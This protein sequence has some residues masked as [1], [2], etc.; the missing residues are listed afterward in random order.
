MKI[1]VAFLTTLIAGAMVIGSAP[2]LAD[3]DG[4]GK[5]VISTPLAPAAIGPYSQAIRVGR[6]L[7][8]SGEIAIDPTTNQFM[9]GAS[10]EDQTDRVLKNLAGILTAAGLTLDNV[11]ATTVYL[12]D[13]NDFA[14]MNQVYATFFPHAPPARATLQVA[15]IP[16]G[17]KVE[18]SA[19]AVTAP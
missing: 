19:I 17:A 9:T 1:Q 10:I 4:S 11:V 18:I 13:L 2:A 15:G 8:V 3:D 6:T 16:K 14:K 7:Y 5:V 12:S